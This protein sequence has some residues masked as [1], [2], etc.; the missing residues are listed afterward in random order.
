MS[1]KSEKDLNIR[2]YKR[3]QLWAGGA[4]GDRRELLL[5]VVGLLGP[6]CAWGGPATSGLIGGNRG[7]GDRKILRP[8]PRQFLPQFFGKSQ[9]SLVLRAW[10]VRG[11][12]IRRNMS[13][14]RGGR[15]GPGTSTPDVGGRSTLMARVATGVRRRFIFSNDLPI[16]RLLSTQTLEQLCDDPPY[17][18]QV[19]LEVF[20]PGVFCQTC[21]QDVS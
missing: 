4:R 11:D 2:S 12:T 17:V 16:C 14:W 1:R 19:T 13:W 10:S 9:T 21:L 7:Q 5:A 8:P 15:R 18:G 20:G 6:P 3:G